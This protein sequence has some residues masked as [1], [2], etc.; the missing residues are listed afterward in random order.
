M[1]MICLI[2][3]STLLKYIG[4]IIPDLL[5][6]PLSPNFVQPQVY[7]LSSTEFRFD[8][9]MFGFTYY[10]LQSGTLIVHVIFITHIFI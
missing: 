7:V 5:S 1:N 3:E 6:K 9:S 10:G 2:L 8:T 4:P